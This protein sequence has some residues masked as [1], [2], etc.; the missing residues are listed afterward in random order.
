MRHF[1]SRAFWEAY[2]KL[3]EPVRNLADKNYGLLK[4]NPQHP[5]LQFGLGDSG[6]CASDY[7]TARSQPK[8][9]AISCGSGSVPT[10]TMTT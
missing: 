8:P 1:A 2:E 9:T 4:N 7:A 5:S 3:P 10:R 6:R